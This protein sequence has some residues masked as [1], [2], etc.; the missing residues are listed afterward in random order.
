[1]KNFKLLVLCFV[2]LVSYQCTTEKN[3]SFPEPQ[4]QKISVEL[5]TKIESLGYDIKTFP[6]RLTDNGATV[7]IEKDMLFDVEDIKNTENIG[8]NKQRYSGSRG[9]VSCS[10]A[11]NIR[12]K[13][14][15]RSGSL[16]RAQLDDAINLWNR[17]SN[18]NLRFVIVTDGRIDVRVNNASLTGTIADAITPGNR[19]GRPGRRIRID[20]SGRTFAGN[21]LTQRQW[22]NVIAHELGHIAGLIHDDENG[23]RVPGTPNRDL[24]SIMSLDA[25]VGEPGSIENQ[26]DLSAGDKNAVR[27]MY[28]SQGN[29]VCRDF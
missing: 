23:I 27:R 11:R 19:N 6:P 15:L 1:M 17:V 22:R 12:V 29:R 13:N 3:D 24:G 8:L 14:N 4:Q 7:V 26:R 21:R 28:G 9:I 25:P 18:S 20:E 2:A 10:R 16:P 5:L